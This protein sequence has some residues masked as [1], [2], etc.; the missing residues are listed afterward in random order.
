MGGNEHDYRATAE[1][2]K[3]NKNYGAY[4]I[5]CH[6]IIVL[7]FSGYIFTPTKAAPK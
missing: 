6:S 3:E 7:Q 1:V 5:S 2:W 4:A